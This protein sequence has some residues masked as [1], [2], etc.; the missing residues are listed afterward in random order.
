MS[1]PLNAK[2]LILNLFKMNSVFF[3]K[4]TK[5]GTL[6]SDQKFVAS[7]KRSESE[8][9]IHGFKNV[10]TGRKSGGGGKLGLI[11]ATP[12]K[13]F[14]QGAELEGFRFTVCEMRLTYC[15]TYTYN[16]NIQ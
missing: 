16:I 7:T 9:K 12:D 15:A 13:P 10:W 8:T 11:A 5:N 1:P 14:A 6:V 3:I 4:T 2:A